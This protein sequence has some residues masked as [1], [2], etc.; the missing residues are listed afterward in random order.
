M[1]LYPTSDDIGR[2]LK[3][4]RLIAG[5]TQIDAARMAEISRTTI[6]EIESGNRYPNMVTLFRLCSIYRID[7]ASI[8]ATIELL[9]DT[10]AKDNAFLRQIEAEKKAYFDAGMECGFQKAFDL[11]QHVL[12]DPK[13][14]GKD[15]FGGGRIRKLFEGLVE[16]EH[17]FSPAFDCREK[18][19]ETAQRD[20][21]VPIQANFGSDY[22][23]FYVRYPMLKKIDYTKNERR[24]KNGSR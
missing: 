4:A 17:R 7:A 15:I 22:Q 14:V 2:R 23:P 24:W 21:D 18:F 5:L 13:Y 1:T 20:L 3:K 9:G 10:M 11:L 6:I 8:I 12:R 19:A 16:Y